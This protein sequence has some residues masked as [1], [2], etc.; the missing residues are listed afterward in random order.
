[1]PPDKLVLGVPFYGRG[2]R[3]VPSTE[4]GLFQPVAGLAPGGDGQGAFSYSELKANYLPR[5]QRFWH[6]EARVP[7]LYD[8]EAG[9]FISYDDPESLAIKADYILA[10]GLGGAMF[11]ELT[12]DGGELVEALHRRLGR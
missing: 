10:R 6:A 8:R 7:W 2:W 4:N 12:Q 5:Y 1:V 11:W 3:G 9:V